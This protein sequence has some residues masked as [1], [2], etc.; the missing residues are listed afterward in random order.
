MRIFR[1]GKYFF[2]GFFWARFGNSAPVTITL[3]QPSNVLD[4]GSEGGSVVLVYGYYSTTRRRTLIRDSIAL[5]S[6]LISRP[7]EEDEAHSPVLFVFQTHLSR[8]R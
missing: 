4:W 1:L 7:C 8:R 6:C 5:P 2:D 3:C